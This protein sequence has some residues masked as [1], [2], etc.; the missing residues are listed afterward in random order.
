MN[1]LRLTPNRSPGLR[2]VAVS[3]VVGLFLVCVSTAIA[4]SGRRGQKS[5]SAPVSIPEPTPVNKPIEKEKATITFIVGVDR[6]LGFSTIPLSFYDTVARGCAERLDDAPGAKIEVAHKEMNRG[7]AVL[8]ARAEKEAFTVWLQLKV[9]SV[10]GDPT[11][12]SNLSQ[13]FIEYA[14]FAPTTA[15]TVT[16]GHTYQQGYRKGGVVVG[17]PGSS[18]GNVSH[19]EYLLKQ[20]AREAAERILSAL[21]MGAP[22]PHLASRD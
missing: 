5:T 11:M 13:I 1:G 21:K 7:D 2:L 18:S 10:S 8:R 9:E 22:S 16:W 3:F 4:Q 19:S 12:V 20:A 17:P 6:S 15:K 14:V